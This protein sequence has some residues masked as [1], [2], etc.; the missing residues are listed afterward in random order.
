M[1]LF[2]MGTGGHYITMLPADWLISTL[3]DTFALQFLW[4]KMLWNPSIRESL[5]L[6]HANNS[7]IKFCES[8]ELPHISS[9]NFSY[10]QP[11]HLF[12]Y[13]HTLLHLQ[14]QSHTYSTAV[15][16]NYS[17]YNMPQLLHCSHAYHQSTTPPSCAS[18]RTPRLL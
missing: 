3:H 17:D 10:C 11:R 18:W 4:W 2:T 12:F 15:Y 16:W 7:I 9:H 13:N 5:K 6:K 14:H 1:A 8:P